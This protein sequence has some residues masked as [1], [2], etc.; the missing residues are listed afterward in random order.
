[1]QV[2][3][4]FFC[5]HFFQNSIHQSVDHLK[6]F[7]ILSITYFISYQLINLTITYFNFNLTHQLKHTGSGPH[8]VSVLCTGLQMKLHFLHYVTISHK[9]TPSPGCLCVKESF[10]CISLVKCGMLEISKSGRKKGVSII[11]PHAADSTN[12]TIWYHNK[13][14]LPNRKVS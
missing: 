11:R 7:F 5:P 9:I 1:M 4:K 10:R 6:V 12:L 2:D 14:L 8:K 13:R 3:F